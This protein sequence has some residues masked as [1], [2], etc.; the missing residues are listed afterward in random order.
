MPTKVNNVYQLIY[1]LCDNEEYERSLFDLDASDQLPVFQDSS[2]NVSADDANMLPVSL[3]QKSKS[4]LVGY[5]GQIFRS[6]EDHQIL[7]MF[8][9]VVMD[10]PANLQGLRRHLTSNYNVVFAS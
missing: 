4:V 3:D 8:P 6:Q 10:H 9:I 7:T 2:E 5:Y 1:L